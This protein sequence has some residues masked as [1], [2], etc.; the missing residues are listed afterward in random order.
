MTHPTWRDKNCIVTGASAGIGRALA[1]AWARAGANVALVARRADPLREVAAE[2]DKTAAGD[3][4]PI[5]GDASWPEDVERIRQTVRDQWN[6]VDLLCNCVGRSARGR[7]LDATV[8]D[9]Q[10][11]WDANVMSAVFCTQAFSSM[12]LES[13]GH[14]VNIGSLASRVAPAYLG[15]YPPVKHALAAF[16]QQLRMEHGQEGLHA[17]LVCPGPIAGGDPN[18]HAEQT[19]HLPPGAARPGGGAR[20][21]GLDPEKLAAKILRYCERR[22]PELIAPG[23]VRLLLIT[24]QISPRAG[25]WLLR[26]F[27]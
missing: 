13:R 4:L 14:V 26:R 22:K 1:D 20:I 24:A 8:E 19:A 11:L 27:T 6:H 17:L 3:I 25:D 15:A 7:V 9:F 21:R 10:Q 5:V 23:Y 2:L 12:L 18:R 16:T